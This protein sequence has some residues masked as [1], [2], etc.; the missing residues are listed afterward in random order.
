MTSS[1]VMAMRRGRLAAFGSVYSWIAIVSGSM[2]A[3]LL[4]PNSQNHGM[5]RELITMP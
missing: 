1:G 4:A 5:S 2:L 3:S